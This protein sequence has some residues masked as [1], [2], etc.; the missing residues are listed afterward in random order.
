MPF[1]LTSHAL[2]YCPPFLRHHIKR[3]KASPMGYRLASGALWS[4]IGASISRV[5]V[6]SSSIIVAR[7]LGKV[8]YGELGIIQSTVG[9]FGTFAGFGL[10][11]TATKYVAEFRVKDPC[12]AGRIIGLS[13]LMAWG[14]GAFMAV[15]L[16]LIAPWLAEH[17]LAA[18]HLTKLLNISSILLF[19]SAVSGAQGG[20]LAGFEAFKQIAQIGLLSGLV[21]L[22]LMA[23][24]VCLF[25]LEG[26]V[27][28]L[29]LSQT[30]NSLLNF[31]GVRKQ[32]HRAHVPLGFRGFGREWK[33]L[34]Q[35]SFP[36]LISGAMVVPVT[37]VCNTIVV[38]QPEGFAQLG[39]FNAANQWFTGLLFLP[40]ILGQVTL[41]ILSERFGGRNTSDTRSILSYSFKF[42][43]IITSP[44]VVV[45]CILSPH[46]MA[47]YGQD[48][49]EAW[50]TLISV[51]ITAG[52]LSILTPAGQIIAASG[53]MWLG[54]A[55]N[56][57]WAICF[58]LFTWLLVGWGSLGLATARMAAYMVHAI[59]TFVF[60]ASLF[61]N[62]VR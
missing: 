37:W 55:M 20:A 11:L 36:S 16:V 1:D 58:V 6:L 7:L 4:L 26:V 35:F 54:S 49:V 41:P 44:L 15:L 56:F 8:S 47:L 61:K 60:L 12:K 9:M 21:S 18:P 31:I 52:L 14:S 2:S 46:I 40:T 27:W 25:G 23:I 22:P 33:V 53:R 48:F 28:G 3:L 50:P 39:L 24:G 30:I 42:N 5:L 51:L 43:A 38:N 32:A 29:I 17:A 13:T 59:W 57:G 45:G 62:P 19:L 34:W 10:G